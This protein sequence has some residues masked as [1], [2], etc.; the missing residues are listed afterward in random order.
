M[1]S[2]WPI[3]MRLTAAFTAMVALVLIGVAIG[4]LLTFGA[5]YDEPLDQ[6]LSSRL[7]NLQAS[8]SASGPC[9]RPHHH[10]RW[11]PQNSRSYP[12]R[13]TN[14][15]DDKSVPSTCPTRDHE[16]GCTFVPLL[17]SAHASTKLRVATH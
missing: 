9:P 17:K 8:S 10:P 14:N 5:T 4:T 2:R 6:T 12:H 16:D 1:I 11:P 7:P 15:M 3:R 13:E